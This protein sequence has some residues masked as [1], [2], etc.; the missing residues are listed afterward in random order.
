MG[1]LSFTL[2]KR[3][4]IIFMSGT[5]TAHIDIETEVKHWYDVYMT[6]YRLF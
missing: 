6:G 3:E 2:I 1:W 5:F 4:G